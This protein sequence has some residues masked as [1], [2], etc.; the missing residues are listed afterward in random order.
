MLLTSKGRYAILAIID[1]AQ[2][3]DSVPRTV[4]DIA[5]R[6]NIS[7]SYLEQIFH[8][9]KNAGIVD[10]IKGPGGGYKLNNNPKE[11]CIMDLI[12]AVAEPIKSTNCSSTNGCK[13]KPEKTVKL[14]NF[15]KA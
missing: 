3:A 11:I 10:S 6:Q 2:K 8:K 9:L 12:N 4:A 1:L 7:S 15:G 14:T 5:Y 13:Q